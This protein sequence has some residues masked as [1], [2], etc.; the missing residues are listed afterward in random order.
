MLLKQTSGPTGALVS[1]V[2]PADR[3]EVSKGFWLNV[4][5]SE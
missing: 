5:T 1:E 3:V 2:R 4:R